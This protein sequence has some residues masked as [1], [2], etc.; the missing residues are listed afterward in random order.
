MLSLAALIREE[1]EAAIL[2][3]LAFNRVGIIADFRYLA[4]LRDA[5]T[6]EILAA[7]NSLQDQGLI[8]RRFFSVFYR[9]GMRCLRRDAWAWV[10]TGGSHGW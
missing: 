6:D 9:P 10:V 1:H 8:E 7:L 5:T 3:F 2:A 4:A